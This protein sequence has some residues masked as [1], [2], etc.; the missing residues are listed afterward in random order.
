LQISWKNSATFQK[1]KFGGGG[2]KKALIE[3]GW[4]AQVLM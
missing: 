3:I 4:G 2:E 1:H